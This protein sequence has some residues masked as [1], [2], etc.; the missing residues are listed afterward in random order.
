[1][2]A[3][4]YCYNHLISRSFSEVTIGLVSK[5]I[6]SRRILYMC[7]GKGKAVPLRAWSRPDG[8]R[9]LRF[10]DNVTT[11]QDCG[12]IVSLTHRPPLPQRNT[13]GTHFY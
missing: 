11:A 6:L 4:V 10:P 12:K 5:F 8:S 1:M 7:K 13:P 9:K 2:C 3:Y